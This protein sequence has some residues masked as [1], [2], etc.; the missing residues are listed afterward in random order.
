MSK[1][2]YNLNP[3]NSYMNFDEIVADV[4]THR[5]DPATRWA[6]AHH[7]IDPFTRNMFMGRWIRNSCG[8]WAKDHPNIS[9]WETERPKFLRQNVD[10]SP[11]HPDNYS[12]LIVDEIER[13]L[14][15]GE[16]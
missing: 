13:R 3:D 10:H 5:L 12:G 7:G 9:L 14:R 6:I 8:L 2:V 16:A 4:L 11:H 15:L 1:P